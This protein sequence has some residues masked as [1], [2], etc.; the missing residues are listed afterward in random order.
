MPWHGTADEA[1]VYAAAGIVAV[2]TGCSFPAALVLLTD[3][4]REVTRTMPDA[5]RLVIAGV[6]RFDNH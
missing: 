3:R 6:L 2:Q 1:V 5:A 4:A